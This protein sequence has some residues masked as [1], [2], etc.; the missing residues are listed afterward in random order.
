M[1]CFY[2]KAVTIN[3][4]NKC[5]LRCG[6]C[7]ASSHAEQ[8]NPITIPLEFALKG[9]SDAFLGIPTGVKADIL[10]FFS[11]GE[12]TQEMGIIKECVAFAKKLNPSLKTELQ[13]NG[14][15]E[16]E[17]DTYWIRDNIDTVWF[18][19]DGPPAIN[20]L[21][22]H[23]PKGE[24][25]TSQIEHNLKTVKEKAKVGVR[26]TIIEKW[27][28]K[29]E[30]LVDYYQHLKIDN[31]VFNPV[32]RP[33]RRGDKGK[34]GVTKGNLMTFAEGFVGAYKKAQ[35]HR[36]AI[37]NW[38]TYNFDKKET[39]SCRCSLPMP[40][41][42]PDGSISSCDMA[43][44]HDTKEELQCFLYGAWSPERKSID[45][46]QKKIH[47]LQN[48]DLNN[49]QVCQDCFLKENCAGG[50]AG[51]IAYQEGSI[52]KVVPEY[53]EATKFLAEHINLNTNSIFISP[54]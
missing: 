3:P 23:G 34:V 29:Q 54:P 21:N 20:D 31:L 16:T 41:L 46:N 4:T 51:R 14:L 52:Y 50:C 49:N 42:N 8:Q 33:I 12:P 7:M 15:F 32:I 53:C 38:L 19:L 27:F 11:P 18:S 25:Y 22:R 37:M 5:N 1:S 48:R 40:Q 10:R 24:K 35:R 44:Y 26:S 6:Y 43:L 28:D 9:I 17:E 39:I 47:H 45:Y 30:E 13:T 36:I 2:H